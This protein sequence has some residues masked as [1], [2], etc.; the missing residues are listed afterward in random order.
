MNLIK[1]LRKPYLAIL[2]ASLTLFAS[3]SQYDN[4]IIEPNSLDAKA[5]KSVHQNIKIE[6][7]K[8]SKDAKT[9]FAQ[10][11][12]SSMEQEYLNNLSYL[13][14]NGI[15]ALFTKHNIDK[16]FLTEFYFFQKNES[17]TEV[18]QLLLENFEFKDVQEATFLFNLIE[19]YNIVE[20]SL[21]LSKNTQLSKGQMQRI[22]WGCAL[23]IAGTVAATAGA[24]F[25]TGGASLIVFLVA[26]GLVTASLIEACG[27]GWG[28]I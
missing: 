6:L 9:N 26:K 11:K 25:V 4:E 22:S 2:L 19:V 27:D 3:C 16:K 8:A 18:Y 24:A 14:E 12:N 5:L 28:D 23:A 15:E 7:N 10:F 1:F 20:S 13:D 21:Q 17:N